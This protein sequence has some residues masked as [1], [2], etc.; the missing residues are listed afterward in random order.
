MK[1]QT[2]MWQKIGEYLKPAHFK[3]WNEFQDSIP[4][5]G[6]LQSV[7][8]K[9][10]KPKSNPQLGWLFAGIYPHFIGH[11]SDHYKETGE[12][13]YQILILGEEIDIEI[14]IVSIDLYLK[15]LFCVHKGIKFFSK[16][17]ASTEDMTE[18]T[19]FLNVHSFNRFGVPTPE[20]KYNKG[21]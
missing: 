21:E 7:F 6:W 3:E 4:D 2:I 8:S 1:K 10:N 18:Y 19:D 20:P 11:Y 14:N 15:R 17:E 13:L 12:P 16:E 5:G 9:P